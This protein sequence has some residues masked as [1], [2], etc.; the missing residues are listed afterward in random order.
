MRKMFS[1]SNI[2]K[3]FYE[4]L[5]NKNTIQVCKIINRKFKWEKV[6]IANKHKKMT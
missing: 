5:R 6:Q 1:T 3:N 4:L 2:G